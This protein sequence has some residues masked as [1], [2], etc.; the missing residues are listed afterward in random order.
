MSGAWQCG[1]ASH[2]Q[3]NI[4]RN[5]LLLLSQV[6]GKHFAGK[7]DKPSHHLPNDENKTKHK[8]KSQKGLWAKLTMLSKRP[9]WNNTHSKLMSSRTWPHDIDAS[10]TSFGFSSCYVLSSVQLIHE[11]A[12]QSQQFVNLRPFHF[13]SSQQVRFVTEFIVYVINHDHD[14]HAHSSQL[15]QICCVLNKVLQ[16]PRITHCH[17]QKSA[18][19]AYLLWAFTAAIALTAGFWT[20]HLYS[21]ALLLWVAVC[22]WVCMSVLCVCGCRCVHVR[23]CR[24]QEHGCDYMTGRSHRLPGKYEGASGFLQIGAVGILQIFRDQWSAPL[25]AHCCF[26]FEVWV[27]QKIQS[28]VLRRAR[29]IRPTHWLCN[30]FPG[31]IMLWWQLSLGHGLKQC[32]L[33]FPPCAFF[34]QSSSFMKWYKIKPTYILCKLVFEY[35]FFFDPSIYWHFELT[36]DAD[37]I[38]YHLQVWELF[39]M[40]WHLRYL[41]SEHHVWCIKHHILRNFLCSGLSSC[42]GDP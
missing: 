39:Y 19:F 26:A 12:G 17:D 5:D 16:R 9:K 27:F 25:L 40:F 31:M 13:H 33:F 8:T 18:P 11:F 29:L 20:Y 10:T 28:V 1:D 37:S 3:G 30:C 7:S 15:R 35:V 22:V 24:T 14:L 21:S 4:Q 6:Q 23:I 38:A 36:W 42:P 2:P 34:I 32:V 41:V